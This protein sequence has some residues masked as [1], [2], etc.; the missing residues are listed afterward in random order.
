M[1]PIAPESSETIKVSGQGADPDCEKSLL[2]PTP[3]ALVDAWPAAILI[4]HSF[5]S[6]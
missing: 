2:H 3:S 6:I 5:A 1:R 4:K